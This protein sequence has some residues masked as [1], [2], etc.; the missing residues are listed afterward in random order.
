MMEQRFQRLIAAE[1]ARASRV[2]L[3]E[4]EA[5][6]ADPVLPFDHAGNIGFIYGQMALMGVDVFGSRVIGQGKASGQVME[7]KSFADFFKRLAAE[8]ISQEAIRRRITSVS[9]FTRTKIVDQI[10][11]GQESGLG[12]AEIGRAIRKQ[13]AGV[14][15]YRGK[16][17]ARTETHGAANYGAYNA[18]KATGLK[19]RKEWVAAEDE[20]TRDGHRLADGQTVDMD[21]P[22]K[23]AVRV[24]LTM[25]VE[26]MTYPGDENAF[27]GNTINC[28]CAVSYIVDD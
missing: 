5:N 15:V 18:A 25:L 6:G 20:R 17:I 2:M 3:D 19:M 27:A 12:V 24:G 7:T 14:S 10:S 28:R 4:Y 26:D 16:L 1:I 22:F 13:V 9:T 21:Q 23:V 8:Y 11:A